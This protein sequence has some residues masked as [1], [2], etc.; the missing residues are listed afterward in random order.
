M[1]TNPSRVSHP[2]RRAFTLV[3]L[4]V[5]IAIIGVLV[6]LLLPAVQAA[7]EAARRMQCK[8]NLKQ[9][10]LACLNYQDAQNHFPSG[11]WN[12][13]WSPDPD[14]G[15]GP[16]QPGSWIYN[17]LEYIEQPNLRALGAGMNHTSPDYYQAQI[18]LCQTPLSA[19]T[20][21][22]RRG[23]RLTVGRW[24][25]IRTGFGTN[26][27]LVGASREG[28]AKSDYAA[29][30]GDTICTGDF[31][32]DNNRTTYAALEDYEWLN[33]SYCQATGNVKNDVKAG[34]ARCQ[35]GA[36]YFRSTVKMAQ[37]TD[38][39][40]NTYLAGEKWV[41]VAG[42]D[43]V[44]NSNDPGFSWGD[45]Q[46]MYTGYESDNHRRA[47][48]PV[49]AK[50]KPPAQQEIDAERFQPRQDGTGLPILNPEPLFGSAHPGGFHVVFCDG[51][52]HNISYEVNFRTHRAL[53]NR[54]D[55]D[56]VD[57]ESL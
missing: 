16:D 35:T 12:F 15:H 22:S 25:Q 9:M 29:S 10:G 28:L 39:T 13:Y 17:V 23:A 20:C 11:G 36:M 37:I 56:L 33:T 46:S 55:G 53:A 27:P 7:R 49:L 48:G 24:T 40:S 38:G 5:V 52:V 4:L 44:A 54:F 8:N 32:M 1:K 19:F 57:L 51:S 42:Y 18:K 6:A 30:S 21:P 34:I 50:P 26:G 45:N 3:E 31:M 2:K 47:W 43:G 14:R 41:E